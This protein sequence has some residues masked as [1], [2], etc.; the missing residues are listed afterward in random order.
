MNRPVMNTHNLEEVWSEKSL[1]SVTS[2][3]D[4]KTA[5]VSGSVPLTSGS[6]GSVLSGAKKISVMRMLFSWYPLFLS[7]AFLYLE[8]ELSLHISH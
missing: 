4:P 7:K 1:S 3:S 8:I 2:G 5:E 6:F